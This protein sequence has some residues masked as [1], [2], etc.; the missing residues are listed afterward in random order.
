VR[1]YSL[2]SRR[3]SAR[4]ALT[5]QA[6]VE[7]ALCAVVLLMLIFSIVNFSF[8]VYAYNFVSYAAREATRYAAV[9]G[10]A[11]AIPASTSDVSNFVLAQTYG[12]NKNNLIVRTTWSPDNNPGSVASVQVQYSLTLI[13]PFVSLGSL[14]LTSSSEMV[15]SQ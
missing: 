15:I 2:Q 10:S 4:P 1:L 9:R 6:Y 13:V 5:G 11:S 12:M 14:N 7:F 3:T 8:A